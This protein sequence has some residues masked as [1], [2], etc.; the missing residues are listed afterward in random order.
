MPT[1][2]IGYDINKEGAAYSA[3]NRKVTEAIHTLFQP[4]GHDWW[5]YLDS[6]YVVKTPLTAIQIR[7]GL[8]HAFDANDELLVVRSAGV[9]AWQGF[10]PKASKW[11]LD[12]L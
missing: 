11:L 4:A 5:H 10:V 9:G 2:I 6:T 1:Y 12:N 3:A 7:D 8:S